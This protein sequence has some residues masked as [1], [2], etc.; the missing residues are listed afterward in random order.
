MYIIGARSFFV[1]TFFEKILG[2]MVG[3]LIFVDEVGDG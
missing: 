3:G 2:E 1:N